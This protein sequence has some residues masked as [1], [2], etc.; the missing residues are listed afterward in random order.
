MVRIQRPAV[1]PHKL[2]FA[3][4]HASRFQPFS[5]AEA[6]LSAAIAACA[7]APPGTFCDADRGHHCES[8]SKCD[9]TRDT[10][11]SINLAWKIGVS[12]GPDVEE[13]VGPEI[14]CL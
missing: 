4:E 2:K 3:L 6:R 11:K 14:N 9:P 10:G 8:A 5:M 13:A 12:R 1:L 7:N